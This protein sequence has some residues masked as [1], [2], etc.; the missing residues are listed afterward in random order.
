MTI[1]VNIEN[2]QKWTSGQSTKNIKLKSDFKS[3]ENL[4]LIYISSRVID[5]NPNFVLHY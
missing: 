5:R 1:L 4:K 3:F 2:R